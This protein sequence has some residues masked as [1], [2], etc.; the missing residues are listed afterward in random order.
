MQ[1]HVSRHFCSTFP[2]YNPHHHSVKIFCVHTDYKSNQWGNTKI[3]QWNQ[4]CSS[5]FLPDWPLGPSASL[6]GFSLLLPATTGY[7]STAALLSLLPPERQNP[8]LCCYKHLN[9][10]AQRLSAP[11]EDTIPQPP[12]PGSPT[13][14]PTGQLPSPTPLC[15]SAVTRIWPQGQTVSPEL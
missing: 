6:T 2:F 8:S 12:L 7:S 3:T 4:V 14:M 9:R 13:P 15:S 11:W 5:K 1:M 10:Q